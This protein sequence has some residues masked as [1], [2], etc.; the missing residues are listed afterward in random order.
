MRYDAVTAG[1]VYLLF[2]IIFFS[3]FLY[4]NLVLLD[5]N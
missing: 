3:L 2:W 4:F 1:T 5:A